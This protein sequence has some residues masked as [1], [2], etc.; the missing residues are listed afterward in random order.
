MPEEV[1]LLSNRFRRNSATHKKSSS[2]ENILIGASSSACGFSPIRDTLVGAVGP[3]H[4]LGYAKLLN[5]IRQRPGLKS[6]LCLEIMLEYMIAVPPLE[7]L[8]FLQI[9]AD[10]PKNSTYSKNGVFLLSGTSTSLK[11]SRQSR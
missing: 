10:Q 6:G 9:L 7:N 11:R 8:D 3:K 2:G 5:I 4:T 1:N